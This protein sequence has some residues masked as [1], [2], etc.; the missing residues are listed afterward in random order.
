V[1]LIFVVIFLAACTVPTEPLLPPVPVPESSAQSE[2]AS[3]TEQAP[4]VTEEEE[5][6]TLGGVKKE[7]SE[8]E[9]EAIA[10][11][12][13]RSSPTFAS[14]GVE[15]SLKLL[16]TTLLDQPFSWQFD[17]EFQC[18]YP[19][20]GWLGSEPTP[21]IIT[22]HEAQ[23]V[24]QEGK[25][26]YAVI[27]GEWDILSAPEATYKPPVTLPEGNLIRVNF[28]KER[29]YTISE[30][31]FTNHPMTNQMVWRALQPINEPD[32]TEATVTG[33]QLTLDSEM[34]L[35]VEHDKLVEM[36]P[37]VYAWSLGDLVEEPERAGWSWDA[38]V[39]GQSQ[40]K[41]AP[42][43]DASRSL[44]KTEFSVADTQTMTI[45][46][47]PRDEQ[48]DRVNIFVHTDED[49]SADAVVVSYSSVNGGDISITEGG[50]RSGIHN[51]PA[52][53]NIP[54]TVTVTLRVTP[55]VPCVI[56]TPYT[57]INPHHSSAAESGVTTGSSVSFTDE[58]GTWTWTADGDYVWHWFGSG[59]AGVEAHW[60][61]SSEPCSS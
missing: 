1:F 26:I 13:L 4:R 56:Y 37:P 44:D 35:V 50:H 45:T 16:A 27:D 2:P 52:E 21:Q 58:V 11:R 5:A 22:P 34:A 38:F 25:V 8:E 24:I 30:D 10:T 19:G 14:R 48:I 15:G 29:Q 31:T 28:I 3:S 33:L 55:K 46:V 59:A 54:L 18:G 23:I 20:Y 41:I 17:Y 43:F 39:I 57:A 47:T 53:V 9:S 60:L 12:L 7:L 36:G 32:K 61:H 51:I 6:T 49:A 40:T 42:G